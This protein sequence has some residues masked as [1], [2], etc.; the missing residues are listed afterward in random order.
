MDVLNFKEE[1]VMTFKYE[2]ILA[3]ETSVD[4]KR[5]GQFP[6]LL[7]WAALHSGREET[8]SFRIL[9]RPSPQLPLARGG[10]G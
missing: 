6:D 2:K 1:L 5:H 10:R 7:P 4:R 8:H 9:T 3:R